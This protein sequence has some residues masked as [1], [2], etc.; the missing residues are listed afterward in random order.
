[1]M[2]MMG[3][4]WGDDG[5]HGDGAGTVDA[6]KAWG[7]DGDD[8][9]MMGDDADDGETTWG[10]QSTINLNITGLGDHKGMTRG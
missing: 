1:M 6:W 4:P 7:D 9:G 3:R 10:P 5:D 2:Q 8:G